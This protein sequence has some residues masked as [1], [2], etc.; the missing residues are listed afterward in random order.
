MRSSPSR[1]LVAMRVTFDFLRPS[2]QPWLARQLKNLGRYIY[3][4]IYR[5]RV[6]VWY[7]SALHQ[8]A[9][10]LL[11]HQCR[12]LGLHDH[13]LGHAAE[14]TVGAIAREGAHHD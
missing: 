2:T 14:R 10:M 12:N 13:G 4:Y 6:G 1:P 8:R 9:M 5:Y 3:I 7:R 11:G